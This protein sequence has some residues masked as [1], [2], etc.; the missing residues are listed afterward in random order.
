ML[1][2]TLKIPIGSILNIVFPILFFISCTNNSNNRNMLKVEQ[3][4]I[5]S[6]FNPRPDSSIN[7][8]E[9]R[10]HYEKFPNRWDA[11]F[12]FLIDSN[13]DSLPLGRND[14]GEDV[15]AVISKYTTKDLEHVYYE[16]HE[17][18]IDLQYIIS[19]EEYIGLTCHT[20][21]LKVISPYN[22]NKDI[23]F[24]DYDGGDLLLAKP[25]RYFIFFPHDIHK[26]CIKV[27]DKSEVKKI[28]IKIRYN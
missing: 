24:Y 9:L 18:Y 26:P 17:K 27:D 15:Y 11:T 7:F 3:N 5:I 28:V 19:G 14:F 10:K 25:D 12:K 23:E 1:K 22:E 21:V 4:T 16:S 13:L 20:A 2:L 8:V 6:N